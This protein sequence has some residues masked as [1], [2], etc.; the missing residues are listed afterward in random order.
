MLVSTIFSRSILYALE[1]VRVPKLTHLINVDC[2]DDLLIVEQNP[3]RLV[4]LL[5]NEGNIVSANQCQPNSEPRMTR[6]RK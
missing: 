1:E 4:E 2:L 6:W 3:G 5:A